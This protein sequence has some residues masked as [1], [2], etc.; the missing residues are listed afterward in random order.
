MKHEKTIKF[1]LV[2]WNGTDDNEDNDNPDNVMT[3]LQKW[4]LLIPNIKNM[5]LN[6]PR[7]LEEL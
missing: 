7:S 4:M 2:E 3:E 6:L 1:L 5:K